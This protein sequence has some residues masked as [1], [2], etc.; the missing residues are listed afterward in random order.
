[1]EGKEKKEGKCF[2]KCVGNFTE[3]RKKV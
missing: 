1:M 3:K 2:G